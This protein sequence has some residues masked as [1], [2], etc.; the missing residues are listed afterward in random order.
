MKSFVD[1]FKIRSNKTGTELPPVTKPL[2]IDE[3]TK[4]A[5]PQYHQSALLMYLRCGLQYEFRYVKGIKVPP[6]GALTLGSSTHAA[7]ARNLIVKKENGVGITKEEALDVYSTDFEIRSQETDWKEDDAGE[8]KDMGARCVEAHHTQIAPEIDPDA[9][10]ESFVIETDAGYNLG[11]TLDVIDKSGLIRDAKTSKNKYD[12][13]SVS[14]AM[15]PAVYDFAYEQTRGKKATGFQYDV[16]IK[17]KKGVETQKVAGVVSDADRQWAFKTI[18]KVH[19]AIQSGNFL[20]ADEDSW[21][22]SEKWCGYWGIC[23][24]KQ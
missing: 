23:K 6:S 8:Q 18:N 2:I 11:G 24:G 9:V 4:L 1:P 13:N 12:D 22:C 19:K 7:I 14:G 5:V 17:K 15:Q 21:V 20:P 3:P 16:L 10:E